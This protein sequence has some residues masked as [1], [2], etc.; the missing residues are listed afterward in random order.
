MSLSFLVVQ[1]GNLMN[2]APK[3][4]GCGRRILTAVI[5]LIIACVVLGGIAYVVAGPAIGKLINAF[6]APISANNDFMTAL[7]AK[8]YTKAYS[9]I[10]PSQQASFGAS[11]DGMK[12]MF[13]TNGWEPS[14]YT[15][16]NIQ[17]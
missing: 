6:A 1:G 17:L 4:G 8:D 15:F 13:G 14:T 2:T 7:I 12:Q 9:L 3:S 5:V 10:H 16:S 11:P